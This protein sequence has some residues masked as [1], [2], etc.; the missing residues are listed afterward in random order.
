MD[1]QAEITR[2]LRTDRLRKWTLLAVVR[3]KNE[4]IIV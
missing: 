2:I 4:E 1:A 3:W